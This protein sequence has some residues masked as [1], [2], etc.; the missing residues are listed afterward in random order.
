MNTPL[1]FVGENG[2]AVSIGAERYSQG[3]ELKQDNYEVTDNLTVGMGQ[4]LITVGTHNEFFKFYNQ[5]FPGSYGVWYFPNTT[6]LYADSAT[7]Y[8]IALPLRPDGPLAQF[9]VNQYGLLRAGR[10]ERHAE[11]EGDLRPAP[12]RP[13]AADEAGLQRRAGLDGVRAREGRRQP[14]GRRYRARRDEQLQCG[15]PVVAAVGLQLRRAG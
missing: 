5:F 13:G 1:I 4:H 2:G 6:A 9:S 15:A 3:N 10:L 14:R 7:H 12:R 11:A 8:E